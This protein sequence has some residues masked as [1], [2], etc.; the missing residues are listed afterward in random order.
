MIQM[1][2]DITRTCHLSLGLVYLRSGR[3]P[4]EGW[5]VHLFFAGAKS[6]G[7][8]YFATVVVP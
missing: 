5:V 4:T 6:G 3:I 2:Y 7:V 8:M 1:L